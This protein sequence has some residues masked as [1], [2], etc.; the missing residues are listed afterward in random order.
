MTDSYSST[1][2]ILFIDKLS[3]T[4]SDTDSQQV[5]NN[6][7]LLTDYC[8][9][10]GIPYGPTERY[11]IQATIPLQ[12][13]YGLQKCTLQLG[14]WNSGT[15][16]Y[17]IEC[18]PSKLDQASR[19]ELD[20]LLLSI[21]GETFR[22]FVLN[23]KVTRLDVAADLPDVTVDD[24]IVRSSHVRKH[25]IY[26]GQT[27]IPETIYVGSIGGTAAY[28]KGKAAKDGIVRLRVERR[29]RPNCPGIGLPH[30]KE[31]FDKIR[32][33][34]T[35]LLVPFVP[36]PATVFFDSMRVRGF[37]R[38]LNMLPHRDRVRVDGVV[39]D[40]NNSLLPPDLW[41][42]WPSCL[43]DSGLLEQARSI[44]SVSGTTPG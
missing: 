33:V 13:N 26:S 44:A 12:G 9:S 22:D 28:D 37:S 8:N 43:E 18:N 36:A 40:V 5:Q 19:D 23:G 38:V 39:R 10:Q 25:G 16:P 2:P 3:A 17:R 27:G 21:T 32:V 24:V 6:I 35:E 1:T 30:I 42:A 20:T 34:P 11:A 14:A 29:L 7:G 31:P 15:N 4:R 41:D